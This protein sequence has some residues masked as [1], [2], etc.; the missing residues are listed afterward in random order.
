MKTKY[1]SLYHRLMCHT[2][3]WD[4]SDKNECWEHPGALNKKNGYPRI[5]VR[6]NGVHYKYYAHHIMWKFHHGPVPKNKEIDHKC[7]NHRCVNPDHLQLL[8]ITKNRRKNQYSDT[9]RASL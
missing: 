3:V 9:Y 6:I 5:S 2:P 7:H 8:S 4:P 1:E